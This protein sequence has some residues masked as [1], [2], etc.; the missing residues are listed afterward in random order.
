MAF[1]LAV[2]SYCGKEIRDGQYYRI[3]ETSGERIGQFVNFCPECNRARLDKIFGAEN[4]F[5]EDRQTLL[6]IGNP[7]IP[8][9]ELMFDP[10]SQRY[11]IGIETIYEFDSSDDEYK[12]YVNI[13][14]KFREWM[15]DRGY[16]EETD[17][18]VG[19]KHFHYPL[20]MFNRIHVGFDS[21]NEAYDWFVSLF[22]AQFD[23]TEEPECDMCD[24][25]S[26]DEC[27]NT[28]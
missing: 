22:C 26:C 2:C 18:Y 10:C 6:S 28:K 16:I 9:F 11:L 15:I 12:Y 8:D 3:Q 4:V 24:C 7:E 14:V 20:D 1:N 5:E 23:L 19:V 13:L 21:V 17:R 25:C 27:A